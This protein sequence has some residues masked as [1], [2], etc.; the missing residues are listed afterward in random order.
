VTTGVLLMTYGA[1]R[2]DADV[3]GYLA[4]VRG[5]RAPDDA[6]VVEMR[7]RYA[8][9]GGSP[10]IRITEAQAAALEAV[11]GPDFRVRA[12]MRYSEPAIADRARE[13][14]DTDG[15]VGIVMSPQW[16]PTL[17]RGYV[18]A[19]RCAVPTATR[20]AGAWH[21]EPAFV[22]ALAT[23]VRAAWSRLGR[24]H[25]LFTAHSLPKRVF[26]T[27]PEYVAQLRETGAAIANAVGLGG[28]EWTWAYQSA[29]HTQ[30]EWLRPDLKDLFPAFAASGNR[31]LL[32]APVQFVADHL[33]ILYDLDIAAAAEAEAAHI[34]YHRV[35]M[36]N[37]DPAFIAALATIARREAAELSPAGQRT[38]RS[39]ATRCHPARSTKP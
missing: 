12:A 11:L 7:G 21:L 22:A 9:I 3:P 39:T 14:N 8:R 17:M 35:P 30:E 25:V 36:P 6:L 16:S 37:C 18:G 23:Q 1:P 24:P 20:I 38:P 26:E 32:V 5:G 29:G 10:L 2:D 33:E 4:R 15:V 31:D 34:R 13:L 19:L 27:E 28:D